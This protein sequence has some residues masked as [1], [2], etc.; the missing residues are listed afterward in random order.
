LFSKSSIG[1][2]GYTGTSIWIDKENDLFV[3]LLSNRVHPSR[4]NNK[5][6]KFRPI[7]HD[8]VFESVVQ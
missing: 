4:K 5:I 8:A 6:L 7:V 2:T 3:I 1:H